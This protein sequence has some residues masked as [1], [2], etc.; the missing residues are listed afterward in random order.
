MNEIIQKYIS[1]NREKM[2][3]FLKELIESP[4][5]DG[6]QTKAQ[7]VVQRKLE[8]LGFRTEVFV[9]DERVKDCPDYCEPAMVNNEDPFVKYVERSISEVEGNREFIHQYHGGSDVRFPI[10][11]GNSRCV[12]IGPY[13]ELHYGKEDL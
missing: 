4:S 12:G 2:I 1:E 5:S 6:K 3:A 9:M 7:E 10:L 8:K 11:Y 13:C